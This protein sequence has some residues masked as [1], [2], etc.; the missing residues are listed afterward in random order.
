MPNRAGGTLRPIVVA[1]MR[2]KSCCR[3][4]PRCAGCPALVL[5]PRRPGRGPAALFDE[6]YGRRS[7]PLPD[8]VA[9]ALAALAEARRPAVTASGAAR[10]V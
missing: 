1:A 8:S 3:S 9:A 5:R 7:A 2:A 4:T 10:R 6:I